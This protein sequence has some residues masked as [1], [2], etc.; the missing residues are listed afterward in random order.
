MATTSLS[1][2][3][4]RLLALAAALAGGAGTAPAPARSF[5]AGADPAYRPVAA[6]AP[7]PLD[8]G[9]LRSVEE[10]EAFV[11]GFAGGEREAYR[12]AGLTVAVVKD[13]QLFFAKGYGWADV[14][15][16]VPV[17]AHRTIFRPGSVSKLF[18]WTA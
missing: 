16:G 8:G 11:D 1:A 9:G 18:T 6:A 14:R 15:N 2:S 12:L 17:D 7:Q 5:E 13:G 3:S 4:C 10:L